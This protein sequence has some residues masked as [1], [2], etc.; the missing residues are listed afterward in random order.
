LLQA[1]ELPLEEAALTADVILLQNGRRAMSPGAVAAA[2]SVGGSL[3]DRVY[4]FAVRSV[5]DT[6]DTVRVCSSA[7]VAVLA[8]SDCQTRGATRCS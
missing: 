8:L 6:K 3:G 5:T 2:A 4:S 1:P 7:G